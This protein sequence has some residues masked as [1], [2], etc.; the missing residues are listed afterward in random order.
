MCTCVSTIMSDDLVFCFRRPWGR[1]RV[2]NQRWRS[3]FELFRSAIIDTQP[4]AAILHDRKAAFDQ[5]IS[6]VERHSTASFE[7][8]GNCQRRPFASF[9]A[10]DQH[11]HAEM[12][13]RVD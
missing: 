5:G 2:A 13:S 1:F 7:E 11:R 9:L 12:Q 3:E 8:P 4:R 10:M 6:L